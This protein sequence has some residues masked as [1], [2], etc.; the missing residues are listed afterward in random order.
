MAAVAVSLC[1]LCSQ[2][3]DASH[4][5]TQSRLAKPG[6]WVKISCPEPG[7]QEISYQTLREWG[8]S[9]PSKVHLY[10]FTH[11]NFT[12]DQITDIL[13]DDLPLIRVMRYPS[14]SPEKLIFYSPGAVLPVPSSS[15]VGTLVNMYSNSCHF[16]LSDAPLSAGESDVVP[17]RARVNRTTATH[18]VHRS[19]QL[20]MPREFHP[21][22][23]GANYYGTPFTGSFSRSFTLTDPETDASTLR[24][25]GAPLLFF[26]GVFGDLNK[27]VQETL[28]F[29]P[30]LSDANTYITAGA[31]KNPSATNIASQ[32]YLFLESEQGHLKFTPS[33][34][35]PPVTEVGVTFTPSPTATARAAWFAPA[36]YGLS[37]LRKN[38]VRADDSQIR[39]FFDSLKG[40]T[41]RANIAF[42]RTI[43]DRD[44]PT[45]S[46]PLVE[47]EV[48]DVTIPS[49]PWKLTGYKVSGSTE[50]Y[51]EYSLA[52]TSS[53][54]NYVPTVMAFRPGSTLYSPVY[55]GEVATQNLH[56]LPTPDMLI[57]ASPSLMEQG[58]RLASIHKE[59][60]GLDVAVVSHDQ[61]LNEFSSG[62]PHAMAY[63]LVAK[64]LY[65]RGRT[66]STASKL[67]YIL[68]LGRS[69]WDQL[70]TSEPEGEWL[71]SYQAQAPLYQALSARCFAS[72]DYFGTMS[73]DVSTSKFTSTKAVEIAVGH[74]DASSPEEAAIAVD[75]IERYL[76]GLPLAGD[77]YH[78]VLLLSD[79]DGSVN[80]FLQESEQHANRLKGY[81][82]S[83]TLDKRYLKFYPADTS[84]NPS[85]IQDGIKESL[86]DGRYLWSYTGHANPRELKNGTLLWNSSLASSTSYDLPPIGFFGTCYL[87]AFDNPRLPVGHALTF[88]KNG[89]TIATIA[90]SRQVHSVPN[91]QFN[92]NFSRALYSN[93]QEGW[94]LGDVY[95][96]ARQLTLQEQDTDPDGRYNTLCYNLFGDPAIPVIAPTLKANA[97]AL[98]G[99][100]LSEATTSSPAKVYP[101]KPFVLKGNIASGMGSAQ[102]DFEGTV[103]ISVFDGGYSAGGTGYTV[104]YD[105]T[106]LARVSAPVKEGTFEARIVVPQ[107]LRT[108]TINRVSIFAVSTDRSRFATGVCNAIQVQP[109]DESQAIADTKA[110]VLTM[111]IDSPDFTSGDVVSSEP[112]L[113]AIISDDSALDLGTGA[114]SSG[115]LLA[116][117]GASRARMVSGSVQPT[118]DGEYRLSVPLG[119][120]TDGEHSATLSVADIAGNATTQTIYFSVMDAALSGQLTV[121]ESP[122][123]TAATLSLLP[124]DGATPSATTL[125][126]RDEAGKP[127][128]TLRNQS[129]SYSWDLKDESGARVPDG[130][131]Y[132][133][134]LMHDGTRYGHTPAVEI[135][136][137][138]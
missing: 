135:L 15:R 2:A 7:M 24:N 39:M 6:K 78:R 113:H 70:H 132:A 32:S 17:Q 71:L 92:M 27:A 10:G 34:N 105:Q 133:S 45:S 119:L 36:S 57:I 28:S 124:S 77:Y 48:W 130:R 134:V 8:F 55:I 4:F 136:V 72:N 35:I 9:D 22:E 68:L 95:R 75:K 122:A 21:G 64:M 138:Q 18:K 11:Q 26:S 29:T 5:A 102:S 125:L 73:E 16:F 30:S 62:T 60:S 108:D 58:Q 23:G 46:S 52:E 101:F 118:G 41:G 91:S 3:V 116:I 44:N 14:S 97:T 106:P 76:D 85:N 115:A 19:V 107:A 90:A 93:A 54:T 13:P 67:K 120:M 98:D 63:R 31:S 103:Y 88:S 59:K 47:P 42:A 87:Y 83:V 112:V 80:E 96:N 109:L 74:L 99:T 84:G 86:S 117:D 40:K 65:E 12:D 38:Y 126:I 1:T 137:V 66:S 49:S 53:D 111:Y 33:T 110:P 82:P 127:I 50:S 100:A 20:L 81:N 25:Q 43:P 123:R 56:A 128:R 94:R 114:V 121:E 79:D 104:K 131:Y 37:Y 69:T 51:I 61:V 89:G 129:L